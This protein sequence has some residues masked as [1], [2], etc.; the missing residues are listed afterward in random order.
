MLILTIALLAIA[1]AHTY[2]TKTSAFSDRTAQ[3][4]YIAQQELEKLKRDYDAT[5]SQPDVTKCSATNGMFTVECKVVTGVAPFS[6]LNLIPVSAKVS[7][8]D[9]NPNSVT[10]ITYYFY[11]KAD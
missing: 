10:V 3:A 9:P 2:T 4:T 1:L 6:D 8:S 7:W 5:T 11:K